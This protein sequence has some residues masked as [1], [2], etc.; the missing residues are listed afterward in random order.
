MSTVAVPEPTDPD[1]EPE[2]TG[3]ACIPIDR[4]HS[5]ETRT[6]NI[7]AQQNWLHLE[8]LRAEVGGLRQAI[9]W[10]IEYV[11]ERDGSSLTRVGDHRRAA[12]GER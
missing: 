8:Q 2:Q 12:G 1:P 11:A 6:A 10:L 4:I 7:E 9:D 3:S 5:L